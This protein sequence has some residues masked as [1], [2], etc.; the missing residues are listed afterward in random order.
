MIFFPNIFFFLLQ[1][2]KKKLSKKAGLEPPHREGEQHNTAAHR[3]GVKDPAGARQWHEA[4]KRRERAVTR[5]KKKKRLLLTLKQQCLRTIRKELL[6][7]CRNSLEGPGL[8][9][10]PAMA[11][12]HAPHCGP[13][14][15]LLA[16]VD[17]KSSS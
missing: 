16:T 2:R 7:F 8:S 3:H 1:Q 13:L 14:G 4:P 5:E 11:K 9:C 12:S 15:H 17:G 6:N 10:C